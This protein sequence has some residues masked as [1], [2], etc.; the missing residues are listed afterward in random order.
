MTKNFNLK[1]IQDQ[2]I[3]KGGEWTKK[4]MPFEIFIRDKKKITKDKQR[5]LSIE[6]PILFESIKAETGKM[7]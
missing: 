4:R 7:G 1:M 5:R 2:T 6:I 3:S